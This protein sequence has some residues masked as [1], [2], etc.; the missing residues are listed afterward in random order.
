MTFKDL[1]R[2]IES[3]PASNQSQLQ[4]LKGKEFW[5]WESASHKRRYASSRGNCCFTHIIGLCKKNGIEKPYY[6]YER[7]LYKS[8]MIPGY[9][10]SSPKLP[11]IDPNNIIYPFKEKHL[12]VKKVQAWGSRNSFLGSWHGSA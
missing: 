4:K 5:F 2:V 12:W 6:D 9:L 7:E 1:Q 10:N 11:S 8:I 3:E